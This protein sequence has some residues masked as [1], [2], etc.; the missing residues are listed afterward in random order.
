MEVDAG[1]D[2]VCDVG[3]GVKAEVKVDVAG[4]IIIL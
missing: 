4:G 3:V 2:E 1:V